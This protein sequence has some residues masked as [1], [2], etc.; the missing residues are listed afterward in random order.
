MKRR[1]VLSLA[2]AV[3]LAG[4]VHTWASEPK[5]ALDGYCPVCL[6]KMNKLVKGSADF[7]LVYDGRKYLFP[8]AKQKQTFETNPAAFAPALG[9]DCVVC[10]VEKGAQVAGK[11]DFFT[12]HEGRLFLFPSSKQQQMFEANPRKYADADLALG[13]NCAVC[14]VKGNKLSPGKAEYFSVYDGRRYLFPSSELK[15]KFEAAPSLFTPAMGGNCTVCKVEMNKT[16][17]GKA[18]YRLVHNGRLY[19]F[20]SEKQLGMFRDNPG[21][22][23][24]ADVALN[25]YCTVCKVEMG[26]DVKGSPEFAVDYRGSRYLFPAAKQRD[27]FLA[28]PGK[29]VTDQ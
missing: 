25:G 15:R 4:T 1:I 22:Y 19:L 5:A 23:A 17:A 9:G 27:M 13:G 3:I 12:V 14:L 18:E 28:N 8:S 24:N 29:Y 26:K 21:K 11:P 2:S 7:S 6:V 20:P 16:V 10:K